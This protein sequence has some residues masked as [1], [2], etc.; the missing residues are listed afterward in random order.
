MSNA[1]ESTKGKRGRKAKDHV[2]SWDGTTVNGLYKKP[3]TSVWR[4]RATGQEFTEPDERLAV[5]RFRQ[6]EAQQQRATLRIPN[7]MADRNDIDAVQ[8]AITT[9]LPDVTP[10]NLPLG[11]WAPPGQNQQPESKPIRVA[12]KPVRIELRGDRLE[13]YDGSEIDVS[14]FGAWLRQLIFKEPKWLAQITGVEQ[15]GWLT[16]VHEP[17]PSPTLQELGNLYAS[18]PGLSGNEA[19]RSKLFWKEFVKAVGVATVREITHEAVQKYEVAV[20]AG[21]YAAKSI[22]HRYRKIRTVLAYGLKRGKSPVD[23]RKALDVLAML[24]VKG[25]HSLDP[26][27]IKAADF[28]AIH[29]AATD[30][31]D[32]TF[33]ALLLTALNCAMYGG[34]VAAL[35]WEEV[36][37]DTGEVVTRRPK[38]KVS[39]VAMLWP[40]S[41]QAIK[42]LPQ[43]RE[44]IFCTRVRSYTTYSVTDAFAKYR[45]AA[46]IGEEVT[47]G[48]IRDAAYSVACREAGIDQARVLAGHRLPGQSDHYVRRNARFVLNACEAIHREFFR[49]S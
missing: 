11:T 29:K 28:W 49:P 48:M 13:F 43:H 47:F 42:G 16:D 5:A 7:M 9:M 46:G 31:K 2:C 6:W 33:A 12:A 22:L 21:N 18:K 32:T 3:G 1:L 26:K 36:N 30:A 27:P 38:T 34:E 25:V 17:E 40:E 23:I 20:Q 14:A 15:L 35:K 10:S 44:Q 39:R 24:E 41:V 19:S 37:L 8:K 45:K 4:I